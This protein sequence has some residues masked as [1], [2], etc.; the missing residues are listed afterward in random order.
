M[1]SAK[2]SV[3]WAL[4]FI[5]VLIGL[6]IH[7][8][9]TLPLTVKLIGRANPVKHMKNMTTPSTDSIFHIFIKCNTSSYDESS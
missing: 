5:T 6:L 2:S 4:Y 7:G 3:G 9:I 8:F 1:R